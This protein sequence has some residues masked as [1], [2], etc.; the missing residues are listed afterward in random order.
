MIDANLG[1]IPSQEMET[2]APELELEQKQKHAAKVIALEKESKFDSDHDAKFC[3]LDCIFS[4]NDMYFDDNGRY[5]EA[6]YE[7]R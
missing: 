1:N 2:Q 7:R 4:Y 3:D 5:L 6:L